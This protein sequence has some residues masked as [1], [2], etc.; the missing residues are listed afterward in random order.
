MCPTQT[1]SS[2]L[3]HLQSKLSAK[4][5]RKRKHPSLSFKVQN[6]KIRKDSSIKTLNDGSSISNAIDVDELFVRL[7]PLPF[8]CSCLISEPV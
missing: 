2:Q 6:K 1:H 3:K 4:S 5:Q 8:I 7:R